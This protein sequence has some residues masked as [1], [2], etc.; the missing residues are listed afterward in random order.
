MKKNKSNECERPRCLRANSTKEKKTILRDLSLSLSEPTESVGSIKLS[1]VSQPLQKKKENK[2]LPH[3]SLLTVRWPAVFPLAGSR[4]PSTRAIFPQACDTSTSER[5]QRV[6]TRGRVDR[7]L[8]PM[9][10]SSLHAPGAGGVRK[11][12][13]GNWRLAITATQEEWIKFWDTLARRGMTKVVPGPFG[14]LDVA[15]VDSLALIT[16][17]PSG[18]L[19]IL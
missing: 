13:A 14:H 18:G 6:F 1:H 15:T 3:L 16:I 19:W 10:A 8:S 11:S 12:R 17:M 2:L 5:G 7:R 9:M 4:L